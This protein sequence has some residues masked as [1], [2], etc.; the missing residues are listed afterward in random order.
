MTLEQLRAQM[1]NNIRMQEVRGREIQSRV[2]IDEDDLRRYYR[3]NI[4][5]FRIPEQ[6]KV[7]EVVVL[8]QGGLPSPE[9]RQR[10]AA[11]LRQA[12]LSG[13]SLA[14]A[15]AEP[16][17]QGTTSNVIDLGWVAPGDLD[18]TLQTA[19]WA[20][21]VGAMSEPVA[22]RGG[23]HL[24]QVTEVR[25]SRIPAF[26]EVSAQIQQRESERVFRQEV[27]KYMAELEKRSLIVANPPDE[28]A[29]F[30]KRITSA[31]AE[32][33]FGDLAAPEPA[34]PPAVTPPAAT[35]PAEKPPAV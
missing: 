6:R 35:N 9:E 17:K 10:L 22:G 5:S 29:G 23:L 21:A 25:E 20:L 13:K 3:K 18:Q 2:S 12:V 19:V 28:A 32:S 30:R 8:E 26:A 33:E 1:R 31:P 34:E 24:L 16:A 4:E 27:I 14:E 11:E 15:A 7:Q